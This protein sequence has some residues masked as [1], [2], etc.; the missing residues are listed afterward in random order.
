MATL[1]D[2]ERACEDSSPLVRGG[3]SAAFSVRPPKQR[4]SDGEEVILI[5]AEVSDPKV[6]VRLPLRGEP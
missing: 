3:C 4:S 6:R 5:I 1:Q 2:I